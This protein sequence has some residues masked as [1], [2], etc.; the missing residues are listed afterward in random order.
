MK[1]KGFTLIEAL[2]YIGVVSVIFFSVSSFVVWFMDFN[3][4]L[5]ASREVLYSGERI[6]SLMDYHISEA[7]GVNYT[8]SS[9]DEDPGKLFLTKE[10]DSVSFYVCSSDLCMKK[11]DKEHILTSK[12]VDVTQLIFKKVEADNSLLIEIDLGVEYNDPEERYSGS[13]NLNSGITPR[14]FYED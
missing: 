8:D 10:G 9:F 13:I 6:M 14:I 1:N 5:K 2:I 12:E 3:G 11:E 7:E 4:Y